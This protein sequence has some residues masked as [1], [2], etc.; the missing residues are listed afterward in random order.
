MQDHWGKK[1]EKAIEILNQG[2]LVIF[3]SDSVYG[4]LVDAAN[5]EAVKKLIAFKARPYGKAISVFVSDFSMI[6][7]LVEVNDEQDKILKEILPGPFTVVLKSKHKVSRLLESEKGTLGV[8]LPIN[9]YLEKLMKKYGKPVTA[10]SANLAGYPPHYS[11]SSL[12]KRLPK[13]KQKLIDYIVDV[14]KLPRNK[15]STVIDLTTPEIK[16]LREGELSFQKIGQFFSQNPNQTKKIS[17]YLLEKYRSVLQKKPL[18][19]IIE[20]ELGVGKTVFVQGIGE[21]LGLKNI[22]SPSYVIYYEYP[23]L[24]HVDLYYL[25][26]KEEFQYLKLERYFKPGMIIC[27][28]WGEKVGEIYE[29]LK[30]VGEVVFVKMRY[31][32]ESNREIIIQKNNK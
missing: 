28:E 23:G 27:F 4:A 15:P 1:I 19:F 14:G 6:K 17:Q 8:R 11:I 30:R 12:L 25:Q 22:I 7:S 20:G 5:E 29:K 9:R 2:G 32:S 31:L 26:D 16:V 3:P 24:V 18:I 21:S 10:T 13:E